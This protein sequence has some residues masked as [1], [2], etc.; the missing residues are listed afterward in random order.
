[1]RPLPLQYLINRLP[2]KVIDNETPF[3]RLFKQQPDYSLLRVFGYA[4]WP[5]MCPYNTRKLQFCSKHCVF[6]S[7]SI[8]H[9]GF[10]CLDPSEGRVYIS[11]DVVFDQH[12][13][14][15][16]TLH[17]NAGARLRAEISLLPESLLN[18]GTNFGDAN[19]LDPHVRNTS[20][21]A[22]ITR[23]EEFCLLLQKSLKKMAQISVLPSI[24]ACVPWREA[25]LILKKLRL[26]QIRRCLRLIQ[27]QRV[28]QLRQHHPRDPF[29]VLARLCRR[30]T[31]LLRV[32]HL[33]HSLRPRRLRHRRIR[34]RGHAPV[35][36]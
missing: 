33:R 24:I 14:P 11:R 31:D 16:S 27:V 17:P 15:F 13:F 21:D 22:D 3:E 23:L 34:A 35:P 30:A 20:P 2:S 26:Q 12:V 9:K 10:K 32:F 7:Y 36:S 5:N 28:R 25:S 19:L 8:Q 4:C 29:S 6:L 18:S 1:M